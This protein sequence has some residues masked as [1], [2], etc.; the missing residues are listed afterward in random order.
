MQNDAGQAGSAVSFRHGEVD[1][2]SC[3]L[4]QVPQHGRGLV[5]GHCL[6]PCGQNGCMDRL[7]LISRRAGEPGNAA[8]DLDQRTCTYRTTPGVDAEPGRAQ[9]N[10]AVMLARPVIEVGESHAMTVG[11]VGAD[12]EAPESRDVL[13][14]I[15]LLCVPSFL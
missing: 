14:R 1:E 11:M 2:C 15:P 5:R 10:E 8:V 13:R 6:A 12:E 7:A 9:G 3:G 4:D